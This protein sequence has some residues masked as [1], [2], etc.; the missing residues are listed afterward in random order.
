MD[1]RPLVDRQRELTQAFFFDWQKVKPDAFIV[2]LLDTFERADATVKDWLEKQF[3][4]GFKT[5]TSGILVIGG[6]KWPIASADWLDHSYRFPLEGVQLKDYSEYAKQHGVPI[7][8]AELEQLHKN[9]GGLPKLFDDYLNAIQQ[10]SKQY[11]VL[12]RCNYE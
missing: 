5:I 8:E 2:V 12:E 4:E 6:R 11:Q 3:L 9:W 1:P 7:P 10:A